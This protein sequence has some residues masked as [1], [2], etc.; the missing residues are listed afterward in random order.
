MVVPPESGVFSELRTTQTCGIEPITDGL[1]LHSASENDET[2]QV[3]EEEQMRK[4]IE[5]THVSLRWEIGSIGK[6]I[7]PY[8]DD[9]H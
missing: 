9:E 3:L 1:L 4:L 6:W 7:F 8:L 5:S 2:P